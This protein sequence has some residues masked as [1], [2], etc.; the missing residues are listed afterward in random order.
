MK[1]KNSNLLFIVP[2]FLYIESYQKMLYYNNI[3]VQ[4]LQISSFLREKEGIKTQFIDL[5]I[6]EDKYSGLNVENPDSE[7][8]KKDYIK[9]LEKNN[10]QEFQ[11]VAII[12]DSPNQYLQ[13]ELMAKILKKQFPNIN[14]IVGGS[15]PT[16]YHEDFI[17]KSSPYDIVIIGEAEGVFLKL[18]NSNFLKK[19]RNQPKPRLL[20]SDKMVD[21]NSLPLPDYEMYLQQYPYKDRFNFEISMSQGCPFDCRFC[22]IIKNYKLKNYS[23]DVFQKNFENLLEFVES[24]NKQ[25]P[26]ITFSDQSFNSAS[27][28]KKVLNYIYENEIQNRFKF[29]C[30]TRLEIVHKQPQL[31][32]L[33]KKT[34][35]IVGFGFETANKNLL[36]EMNKTKNPKRYVEKMK[37]IVEIYKKEGEIYC[38]LNIIAGFPGEN[39]QTFNDTIKF[40]NDNALHENIQISPT[41]FINDPCTHVYNNMIYYEENYN[42]KFCKE[43]WKIPSDPLKNSILEKPSKNYYKKQLIRDYKDKYFPILRIFKYSSFTGLAKWKRYFDRWYE[44][45]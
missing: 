45:I 3:P 25:Q 18:F 39:Q 32:D 35:M 24:Y 17:Y 33:F 6:E 31:I 16:V 40:I 9:V 41:L 29:S 11:N 2:G 4:T 13:T 8:F 44:E 10:I 37:D 12:F 22:K 5:R 26:K 1:E 20:I 27:I 28:S 7:L 42:T 30:Q 19:I 36:I 38:R 21:I 15:H 23:F 34:K 43:W 14:L